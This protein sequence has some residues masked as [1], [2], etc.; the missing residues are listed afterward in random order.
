MPVLSRAAP[1]T[2]SPDVKEGFM[3]ATVHRLRRYLR[4]RATVR[5]LE[6]LSGP[7]LT[8]LLIAPRDIRRVAREASL[9]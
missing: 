2:G 9:Y 4:Y 7:E 1:T 6:G 5:E 3:T 8:Q